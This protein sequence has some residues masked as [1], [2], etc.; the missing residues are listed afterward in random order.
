MDAEKILEESVTKHN[1]YYTSSSGD[2]DSKAFRAMKNAYDSEKLVKKYKYIGH[3]Q[4]S[5]GTHLPKKKKDIKKLG[6]KGRLSEA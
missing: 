4:K 5:V 1:L 2:G 3:Y 6:E